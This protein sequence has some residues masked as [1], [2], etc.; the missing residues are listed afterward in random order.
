M[1]KVST[2]IPF[3]DAVE[4]I[5]DTYL[6]RDVVIEHGVS[7]KKQ[8][9]EWVGVCPFH[10]E[11]TPSFSVSD[12]K[13]VFYCRGCHEKG[14]VI[15]FIAKQRVVEPGEVIFELAEKLGYQIQSRHRQMPAAITRKADHALSVRLFA[16]HE[17]LALAAHHRLLE[18]LSD[19]SDPVTCYLNHRGIHESDVRRYGLGFWP[20]QESLSA[21]LSRIDKPV[22]LR[23]LNASDWESLLRVAGYLN[24]QS[25][26]HQPSIFQGRLLFP[27][28]DNRGRVCA[29][30]GRIVPGVETGDTKSKYRN[31]PES[32][33]F[34]KS[35]TLYGQVPASFILTDNEVATWWRTVNRQRN[36]FLV[37]G[38][39]D[40][41]SLARLGIQASAAMG[42]G[43]T[44]AHIKRLL[45]ATDTLVILTDG[46]EAGRKSAQR[47]LLT[48]LRCVKPGHVVEARLLPEGSD[49]DTFVANFDE[50]SQFYRA[51]KGLV[52]LTMEDV[53]FED[54]VGGIS[55]PLDI[56]SR[57]RLER[58]VHQGFETGDLPADPE[59]QI[60]FRQWVF[61]LTGYR[62]SDAPAQ[63]EN[64]AFLMSLPDLTIDN[65]GAFWLLRFARAPEQLQI[66]V[67]YLD[68]W[69]AK[70]CRLGI[71]GS[72]EPLSDALRLIL[73]V[74]DACRE[75]MPS[76]VGFATLCEFSLKAGVPSQWLYRWIRLVKGAQDEPIL[77]HYLDEAVLP[78]LWA[79]E[80]CAWLD[81][82]DVVLCDSL[83]TELQ[84]LE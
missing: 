74:A 33:V 51:F 5:K 49:P 31:S 9:K 10:D 50:G 28:S 25:S 22:A 72:P 77:A 27:I 79:S 60:C 44:E 40:V 71:L 84:S 81:N 35:H 29:M 67:P 34:D 64:A 70:D 13:G 66:V 75:H 82:I 2:V 76:I 26:W 65:S 32:E 6:L 42:T 36:T 61:E 23:N 83:L 47:G 53:W 15:T 39:T 57:V 73:T 17:A 54:R 3:S 62:V 18:I 8:G 52:R 12:E 24:A 69:W 1:S 55:R 80:F 21:W 19:S 38:Y 43:I 56:G 48:A 11:K 58:S 20:H 7:L 16:V 30:S 68:R 59:W 4:K 14:D 37:E 78:D 45:R 41:I 46:D 63:R